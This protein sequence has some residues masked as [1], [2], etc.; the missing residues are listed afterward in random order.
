MA[1]SDILNLNESVAPRLIRI[2][3]GLTLIV[4]ALGVVLGL[5]QGIRTATRMPP[6]PPLQMSEQAN[7]GAPQIQVPPAAGQPGLREDRF[8]RRG[9]GARRLGGD[10]FRPGRVGPFGMNLR[11]NP[12]LFGAFLIVRTL[13]MGF[14]GLLVVRILA[15]M[16]LSVLALN[17]RTEVTDSATT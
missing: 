2:L 11:R 12:A 6:L 16:A 5:V 1:A 9:F 4:I 17:Q 13:M 15:E 10:G 14:I 3:Y 7:P 8:G